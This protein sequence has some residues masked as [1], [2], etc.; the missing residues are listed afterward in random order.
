[1]LPTH[2]ATAVLAAIIFGLFARTFLLQ[3]V[4]VPSDS[5]TPTLLAGDH[6]LVD[7][8]VFGAERWS[9]PALPGLPMRPVRRFDLLVFR[10]ASDPEQRYV[11]RCAALPGETVALESGLLV[12]GG[13]RLEEPGGVRPDTLSTAPRRLAGDQLFVLGDHR[14]RSRDSRSWGGIPR[15][16]LV[17]RPLLVTWSLR[18][19]TDG[20]APTKDWGKIGWEDFSRPFAR[21]LEWPARVRWERCLEPVE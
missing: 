19:R 8:F 7:K 17:G 2:L 12:I 18:P 13:T 20:V 16:R 4:R 11:K 10:G 1:M 5:M 21:L 6:L 14:R 3:I 15:R 9:E